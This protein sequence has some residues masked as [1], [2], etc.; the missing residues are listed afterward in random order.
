M[1]NNG[2]L[3]DD[4]II[5]R[6]EYIWLDGAT[7]TQGLRSKTRIVS[8]AKDAEI[9][10]GSF[11]VWSYD[12]SST[13]QASGDDSDLLLQPVRC[14]LDPIRGGRNYLVMCEVLNEDGTP[15]ATNER[16]ALRAALDNG[17]ADE[18]PVVGFE[19]EYTLFRDGR[20]LGF[21]E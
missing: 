19:Q 1:N 6:A 16:A 9:G 12:G 5:A 15:H 13:Y 8:L 17:G 11:P 10:P 20:P 7:P 2:I 18:D 14:V 3:Y 4:N 21:P